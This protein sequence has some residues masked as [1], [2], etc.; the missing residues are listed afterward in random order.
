MVNVAHSIHSAPALMSNPKIYPYEELQTMSKKRLPSDVDRDHLEVY[1]S[2]L[3]LFSNIFS[4]A[5]F[6]R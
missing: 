6:I 4:L 5:S 1:N 3:I 2:N